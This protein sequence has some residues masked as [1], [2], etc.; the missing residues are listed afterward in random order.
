MLIFSRG[1]SSTLKEAESGNPTQ[2]AFK[3]TQIL[4]VSV[5]FCHFTFCTEN[6][7]TKAVKDCFCKDWTEHSKDTKLIMK[8]HLKNLTIYE[9]LVHCFEKWDNQKRYLVKHST[10]FRINLYNNCLQNFKHPYT[11]LPCST[12]V[13]QIEKCFSSG[14]NW[15]QISVF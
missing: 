4:L 5:V 2:T 8:R 1:F 15:A 6:I 14:L 13:G 7:L 11:N 10:V 3:L 12:P 9:R